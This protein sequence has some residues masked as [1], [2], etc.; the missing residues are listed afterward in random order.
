MVGVIAG[1]AALF[2]PLPLNVIVRGLPRALSVIVSTPDLKPSDTGLKLTLTLILDPAGMVCG[3]ARADTNSPVQL[4][5]ATTRSI[6]AG[7]RMATDFVLVSFTMTS[8]KSSSP[9]TTLT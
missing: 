8:P 7:F 2:I 4:A 5:L 9:G 6:G 3:M 1:N